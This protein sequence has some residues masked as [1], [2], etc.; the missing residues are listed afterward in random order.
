MFPTLLDPPKEAPR[1]T[2]AKVALRTAFAAAVNTDSNT[3]NFQAALAK[4]VPLLLPL[5][6]NSADR[7]EL[8]LL[9]GRLLSH[10]SDEVAGELRKSLS[11]LDANSQEL[12]REVCQKIAPLKERLEDIK[13]A[14]AAIYDVS[15]AEMQHWD[16][17]FFEV[18][19]LVTT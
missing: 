10:T 19:I 14:A 12:H 13:T 8:L 11:W 4:A 3:A 5:I 18:R 2:Q 17:P 9:L 1:L 6:T 16:K 15:A 7:A